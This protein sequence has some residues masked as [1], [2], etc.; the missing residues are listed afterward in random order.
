[1]SNQTPNGSNEERDV[2]LLSKVATKDKLAFEKLYRLYYPQ[3]NRYLSRLLRQPELVEEVIDDTLFV[4]WE[5]AATFQGRSKVSTWITGIA[6]LK[7][8]KSLARIKKRPD[9]QTGTDLILES[10]NDENDFIKKLGLQEWLFSGMDKISPDQ[11]SVLE[12]TYYF[13]YS[14]I[15]ISEIMTCP[16]NTVKTRM[17]HA[18]RKLEKLLPQIEEHTLQ[19]QKASSEKS[20]AM[21]A[22]LKGNL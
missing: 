2:Y 20:T 6:Y 15:E 3:L 5:K 13:G 10:I 22:L 4:V 16:V 12:L 8:I 14:Y 21:K 7:G 19:N 9:S 11:R 1:M 17:F 18:R